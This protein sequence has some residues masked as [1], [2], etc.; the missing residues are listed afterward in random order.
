MSTYQQTV[1]GQMCLFW[2]DSCINA[3]GSDATAQFNCIQARDTRCGN[4]TIEKSSSNSASSSASG[5]SR[6]TGTSG[7]GSS[8]ASATGTGAPANSQAAAA[9][10]ST[11]GAPALAGGLLALFG[12]AL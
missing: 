7:S 11:F 1:P 5:T 8:S 6:P 10:M 3:T 9:I 2:F 4:Q 12:L